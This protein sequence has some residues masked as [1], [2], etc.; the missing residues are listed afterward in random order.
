LTED[1][2]PARILVVDDHELNRK[3]LQRLL[4]RSGY[5]V[6]CAASL[7]AAS[8]AAFECP[9]DLIVLDLNLADGDGLALV[10]R[11]RGDPRTRH[12]VIVACT[13]ASADGDRDRALRAG[14]DAYVAKPIDTR[15]F[16]ALVEELLAGP[17]PL[18]ADARVALR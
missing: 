3:L 4:E 2:G 13:A 17:P 10:G 6:H 7:T 12:A 8:C 1:N 15:V 5:A 9:P 18:P 11:L 16:A 14:C